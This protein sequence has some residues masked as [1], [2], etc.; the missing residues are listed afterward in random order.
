MA[1]LDGI[2]F[3]IIR[4][5]WLCKPISK[6]NASK[7]VSGKSRFSNGYHKFEKGMHYKG[8]PILYQSVKTS[9][10]ERG[11]DNPVFFL[12]NPQV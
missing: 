12:S 6:L 8:K 1:V 10:R 11:R 5:Y 9:E 3:G 7:A 2:S 4:T